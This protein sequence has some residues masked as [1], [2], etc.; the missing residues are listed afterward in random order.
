MAVAPLM[1]STNSNAQPK[2]ST[3]SDDTGG[4]GT[5]ASDLLNNFMT[6]LVA[7]MQNQDP[8]NPMDNSQLTTQLA[9]FNTAAG[10]E[11]L[12]GTLNSVGTLVSSMQQ[13]NAAEWV[14]RSVLVEGQPVVETSD[15]EGANKT[16]SFSLSSGAD[17]VEVTLTDKEGNSYRAQI[18]NVESGIHTCNLNDLNNFQPSDPPEDT[19]YTV[20]FTATNGTGD[21]PEIVALKKANVESVS[22]SPSGSVLQLGVDGSAT[23][24]QVY[25]IE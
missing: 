24:G 12:N 2:V 20:S 6:L 1:S 14:G 15:T 3:A 23:L 7:Q 25:E 10:V 11:Q 17:N 9:Q 16:F 21:A 19:T 4:T 5:S 18:P 13:M 22:F 8:T